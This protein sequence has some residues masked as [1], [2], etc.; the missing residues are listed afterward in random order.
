VVIWQAKV[1]EWVIVVVCLRVV[2]VVRDFF[3]REVK[4]N[5]TFVFSDIRFFSLRDFIRERNLRRCWVRKILAY[6]RL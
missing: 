5:W 4:V 3:L 1:R 6:S 2:G